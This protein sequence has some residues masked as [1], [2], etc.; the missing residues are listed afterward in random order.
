[1]LRDLILKH[2]YIPGTC[3]LA[4]ITRRLAVSLDIVVKHIEFLRIGGLVEPLAGEYHSADSSW[5]LTAAGRARAADALRQCGYV[6]PAPVSLEEYDCQFGGDDPIR[7]SPSLTGWARAQAEGVLR[8]D[9]VEAIGTALL[10]RGLI[11]IWGPPGSGKSHL[12][13]SM[14]QA[15]NGP[16]PVPHAIALGDAL[17]EVFDP[18]FHR[19]SALE[20][21]RPPTSDRRWVW[22]EPPVIVLPHSVGAGDFEIRHDRGAGRS[23]APIQ[24]KANRGVIVVDDLD[25]R[26]AFERL[27]SDR[28]R[29]LID[30]GRDTFFVPGQAPVEL[31]WRG[32]IVLASTLPPEQS[33]DQSLLRRLSCR[34]EIDAMRPAAYQAFVERIYQAQGQSC[35][36]GVVSWLFEQ[37]RAAGLP[38]VPGMIVQL[39]RIAI[40]RAR[41]RG[42]SPD[43]GLSALEHAWQIHRGLANRAGSASEPSGPHGT[44]AAL[45]SRRFNGSIDVRAQ[46]PVQALR[47]RTATYSSDDL[48]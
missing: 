17:L 14:N 48:Q 44:I 33:V 39:I 5:A 10:G 31:P 30:R 45:P 32:G 27:L 21:S 37:Q 15:L 8:P 2:L 41:Y 1:M 18:S 4:A 6:G 22:C 34:V 11:Y 46:Q 47:V 40:D 20:G 16:V 36:E 3:T 28:C 12:L 23:H 29:D 25:R 38:C 43:L 19:V 35:P 9:Q 26:P 42:E 7:V 24:I 13:R